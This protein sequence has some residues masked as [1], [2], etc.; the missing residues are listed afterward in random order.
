MQS[1]ADACCAGP[2]PSG[3]LFSLTD[4]CLAH[5]QPRKCS[6]VAT[7][8]QLSKRRE[9]CI[10]CIAGHGGNRC[11]AFAERL[12]RSCFAALLCMRARNAVRARVAQGMEAP[13]PLGELMMKGK[14]ATGFWVTPWFHNKPRE[15]QRKLV[16][17]V[18]ASA[19]AAHRPSAPC[20]SHAWRPVATVDAVVLPRELVCWV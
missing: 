6:H 16:Q 10:A 18:R 2:G 17:Q 12:W 1:S 13:L 20:D 7:P 4:T 9:H 14:F 3:V 15:E 19:H 8:Q 5:M 11:C